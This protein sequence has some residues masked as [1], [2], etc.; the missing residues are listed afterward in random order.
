M[1]EGG[2]PRRALILAGGGVKVAFQAGV[3]QVW[4][5]EAGLEFDLADGASGGT[6]NLAMYC[7]G[8]SG[9]EIAENWRTMRPRESLQPNL[10]E[11]AKG[12]WAESIMRLERFEERTFAHWGLDWPRIRATDVEATFNVYN[13][14]RHQLE[15]LTPD[16]MTPELLRACVSLPMWFPP[17]RIGGDVYIDPVFITDANLEEAI[18]RGADELW[19]VWTVSEQGQW[20]HGFIANYFQVIE[21]S[22]FGHFKRLLR[23]IEESNAALAEGREGEFGRPIEVKLLRAEVPLHYIVNLSGARLRAAVERGVE[24]GRRWCRE[25]GIP[26]VTPSRPPSRDPTSLS[27][28]E[29]MKGGVAFGEPAAGDGPPATRDGDHELMFHLTMDVQHVHDFIA[30]P[31]H[32]A[33]ARGY[34]ECPAL[35]GRPPVERGVFNLFVDQGDPSRKQMLYRLPFHD[36]AG[37]PLTLTGVKHVSD[38]PG[39]DAWRDTTTLFVRVLRGHLEPGEDADAELVASG[40]I[41]IYPLDFL[42]QLSTFRARAP[43]K[44]ERGRALVAFGQAFMGNLWDVYA[45][46]I[47][48]TSPF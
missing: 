41:R 18:R 1:A 25:Q 4:L 2:S 13:F 20:R 19:I 11:W 15:V 16:R 40:I 43:S 28:T 34:V 10:R 12:P 24:A 46:R 33:P 39:A 8:M 29:E 31:A 6:F 36:G 3:L 48:S 32:E 42:R 9:T 35:G 38:D 5:D 21:T 45:R 37:H 30:D 27:F 23:R 47:L 26:L 44:R 17:V 14:S 7:Q 22:A